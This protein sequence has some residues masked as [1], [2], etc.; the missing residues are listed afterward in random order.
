MRNDL[1]IHLL[2]GV[3]GVTLFIAAQRAQSEPWLSARLAL[4]ALILLRGCPLCWTM[5]FVQ[6][7]AA[8]FSP[9]KP[10]H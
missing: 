3:F 4:Y 8:C 2:K 5:R 9:R 10:L 6:L 1:L 7:V